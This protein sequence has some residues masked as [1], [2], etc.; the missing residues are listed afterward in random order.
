[1]RFQVYSRLSRIFLYLL[2]LAVVILVCFGPLKRIFPWGSQMMAW[3]FRRCCKVLNI[4]LETLGEV[5]QQ[6][7][8]WV[9]NHVSWVDIIALAGIKPLDFVAKSEVKNW[10]VIGTLSTRIG[11]IFIN[12]DSKFSAYRTLPLIQQRLLSGNSVVVFPEGTTSAGI[13]TLS[14]K[15]MFYQAAVREGM[16]VQPICLKYLNPDGRAS[17]SLPFLDDDDFIGSLIRIAKQ[18]ESCLQI[19]FLSM[20]NPGVGERKTMANQNQRQ[21]SD[22]LAVPVVKLSASKTAFI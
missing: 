22:C 15:P 9:A 21:I 16:A 12:R 6:P 2:I 8:L 14:F 1:M 11:A 19:H 17:V 7:S 5:P 4:K 20:K 13:D 3:V 18:P 10:P